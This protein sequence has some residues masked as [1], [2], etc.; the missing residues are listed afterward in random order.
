MRAFGARSQA[1][2]FTAAWRM[3][4][5]SIGAF[6]SITFARSLTNDWTSSLGAFWA[7][8]PGQV[9]TGLFRRRSFCAL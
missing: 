4:T 9:V 7:S 6:V 5:R 2:A 3:N 1:T 8:P